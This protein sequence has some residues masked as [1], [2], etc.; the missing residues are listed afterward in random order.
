MYIG[1]CMSHCAACTKVT[2]HVNKPANKCLSLFLGQ[3]NLKAK[4]YPGHQNWIGTSDEGF[5]DKIVKYSIFYK[6]TLKI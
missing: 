2:T 6:F 5:Y 3:D 4:T 1:A